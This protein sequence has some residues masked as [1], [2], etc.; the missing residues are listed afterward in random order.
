MHTFILLVGG[1]EY[2]LAN[3]V[4][5]ALYLTNLGGIFACFCICQNC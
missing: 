1:F 5:Q 2:Y 3:S 4:P